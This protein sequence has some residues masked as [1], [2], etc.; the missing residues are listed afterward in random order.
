MTEGLRSVQEVPAPYRCL[1]S[2]Y[3]FFNRIQSSVMDDVLHSDTPVVVS[4]PTGSGKTAVLELALVR[5]LNAS[6]TDGDEQGPRA[7]AVYVSPLK[8][9]CRERLCE[10]RAKLSS[11]G[12]HCAEYTGDTDDDHDREALLGAQLLLTTPEK[13]DGCTRRWPEAVRPDL[14]LV[15]EMQTVSEA[16]RGAVLEAVLTRTKLL[17]RRDRL[18]I[19]GVCGCVEN[20]RDLAAWLG[21]DAKH[22]SFPASARPVPLRRVVLGYPC[23]SNTSDFRFD[24]ALS[25]KLAAVINAHSA[26]KPA[27]VFCSTRKGAVQAATVLASSL[28][29]IRR[30]AF[31]K[32]L[33]ATA[34]AI[35]DAKLRELVQRSGVGWHHAGLE[36][37]DRD[38]L[39]S[40]FRAGALRALVSTSTLAVGVNLPAR[41]VV[42]RGT[43]TYGGR[44]QPY[45]ELVLEQMVGRAG[46]PQYDTCG[47]AVI[48]T[49]SSLKSEYEAQC[50][51]LSVLESSLLRAGLA[52]HL[53]VELVLGSLPRPDLSGC[54]AWARETFLHVRLLKNP[55]HYGFPPGLTRSGAE[56]A[57]QGLCREAVEALSAAGLVNVDRDTGCLK[58]NGAGCLMARQCISLDTMRRFSELGGKLSLADLLW[59]L[60]CCSEF[61]D[62][63]LRNNEKAALNALNGS[64]RKPGIRFPMTG[65]IKTTEMKVNCLLQAMLGCMTVAD[66]SLAQ[67]IPRIVVVALRLARALV[68][69]L[70]LRSPACGFSALLHA[71]TLHKCLQAR[72][73]EDSLH[74]ARQIEHIGPALSSS[75]VRSGLT[76][77]EKLANADPRELELIVNRRPPFG[78]RV[79]LAARRIPKYELDVKQESCRGDQVTLSLLVQLRPLAEGRAGES[80]S[81]DLAAAHL[82]I[83]D[84]DDRLLFY[85]RIL[86]SHM[87]A[88]WARR[89]ALRRAGSGDTLTICLV[90]SKHVGVD[91]RRNFIPRYASDKITLRSPWIGKAE[92]AAASTVTTVAPSK[93]KAT[94]SRLS[95]VAS[96]GKAKNGSDMLPCSD[97]PEPPTV[98]NEQPSTNDGRAADAWDLQYDDA[99]LWHSLAGSDASVGS[100]LPSPGWNPTEPAETEERADDLSLAGARRHDSATDATCPARVA[101]QHADTAADQ[102]KSAADDLD[103]VVAELARRYFPHLLPL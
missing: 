22:Y 38:A 1:F 76:T 52:E 31:S 72:L 103:A 57:L 12:V 18:R 40:L 35:R 81:L 65:R 75:L 94:A 88:G 67:D 86:P 3:P 2:A 92:D 10:W 26:G 60:S 85:Q 83:G 73:W 51:G 66:P 5:L 87:A 54:L 70:V 16:D 96:T 91:V 69:L 84:V 50:Q 23:S 56:E 25:Y 36:A 90:S 19:V 28:G 68:S 14:V 102:W 93:P 55:K 15:D 45:P 46:R 89:I 13:W 21:P 6:R 8:A 82:V 30:P 74:V 33:L 41:L 4:A 100:N 42:V 53:N 39:E 47:T 49:K 61:A 78:S 101:A 34:A 27:L 9:L 37:S 17:R 77:L 97:I 95:R 7:R 44:P 71:V 59:S 58:P 29:P 43:T 24:M 63:Q 79:V 32:E 80:P 11:V 48:M 64:R 99:E 20:A 62:V 98:G